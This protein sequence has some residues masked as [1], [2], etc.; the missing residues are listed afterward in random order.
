M[1]ERM[2][3]DC[4]AQS[5][6]ML[7]A[8]MAK[9]KSLDTNCTALISFAFLLP[10]L[11][12]DCSWKETILRQKI[13]L[14]RIQSRLNNRQFEC[15]FVF[16]DNGVLI[17]LCWPEIPLTS[18]KPWITARLPS[19]RGLARMSG[20]LTFD[21]GGSSVL[22]CMG[23]KGGLALWHEERQSMSPASCELSFS[24]SYCVMHSAIDG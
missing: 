3:G 6:W 2:Q 19:G 21:W 9:V 5:R 7:P 18:G 13:M 16:D 20:M 11:N 12:I 14:T 10:K 4:K 8:R 22:G 15:A 17:L 1:L 23:C 24:G